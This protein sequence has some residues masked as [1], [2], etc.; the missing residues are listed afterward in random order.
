MKMKFNKPKVC[1]WLSH[2][3]IY[4]KSTARHSGK[5][6]FLLRFP[7]QVYYCN[8]LFLTFK[9]RRYFWMKCHLVLFSQLCSNV[10]SGLSCCSLSLLGVMRPIIFNSKPKLVIVSGLMVDEQNVDLKFV[11]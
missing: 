6:Q 11:F 2:C 9:I 3:E 10:L 5:T 7:A 4:R 8:F 1:P